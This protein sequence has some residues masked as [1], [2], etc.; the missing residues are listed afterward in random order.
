MRDLLLD[1]VANVQWALS[2]AAV[3]IAAM[4]AAMLLYPVVSGLLGY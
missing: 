4:V 2:V 3:T 1:I